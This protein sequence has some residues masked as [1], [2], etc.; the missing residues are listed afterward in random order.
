MTTFQ[1]NLSIYATGPC[2]KWL[3]Y[4]QKCSRLL[5]IRCNNSLQYTNVSKFCKFIV[6]YKILIRY[7]YTTDH[8]IF[9]NLP[10]IKHN[11][12]TH[13]SP[14]TGRGIPKMGASKSPLK[15]MLL[16]IKPAGFF[17]E[18]MYTP[19]SWRVSFEILTLYHKTVSPLS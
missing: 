19:L 10:I 2:N 13:T 8:Y 11:N 4:L 9:N 17:A 18:Q 16:S 6:K 5:N 7:T 1:F 3:D 14:P 12:N 15:V